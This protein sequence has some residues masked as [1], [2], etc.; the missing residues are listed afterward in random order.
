MTFDGNSF[1]ACGDYAGAP[2]YGPGNTTAQQLGLNV[3]AV[4]TALRRVAFPEEPCGAAH[5]RWPK[6]LD[7]P[8]GLQHP[9]SVL[10]LMKQALRME[11]A[12]WSEGPVTL[13]CYVVR[14]D[15]EATSVD[16]ADRALLLRGI[17]KATVRTKPE[18]GANAQ[19][20]T[21]AAEHSLA[22]SLRRITRQEFDQGARYAVLPLFAGVVGAP[23]KD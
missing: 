13:Q 8:L 20:N 19:A 1:F 9:F 21:A 22:E 15:G 6:N 10:V 7:L 4:A 16:G 5:L 17:F 11:Q 18:E 3:P 23:S 12:A 14:S 2:V